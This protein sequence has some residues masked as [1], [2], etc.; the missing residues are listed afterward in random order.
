MEISKQELLREAIETGFR[1][2]NFEL[3]DKKLFVTLR[4]PFKI[5]KDTSLLEKCPGMCPK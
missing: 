5:I 1:F 3:K 4:E 2:E